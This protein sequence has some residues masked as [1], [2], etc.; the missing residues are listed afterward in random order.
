MAFRFQKRV[1]L[2]KGLGINISKSGI[3]PSY[4]TKRG[5]LS[6]K[7]YS[8]RTG[9]SGLN[10]RKTFSKGKNSGC[11]V[12][13]I[14]PLCMMLLILFSCSGDED[15]TP[16]RDTNCANYSSQNTAQAAFEADPECRNDLDRDNDG[17]ACEEPGNSV[18]NCASTSNCG[19]SNKNKA[20][21]EADP[22]CR[23]IVGEGC[24]CN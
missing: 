5:S 14:L 4:R 9:I 19:C 10:Y 3:T 24:S 13:L 18:K 16:C 11:L 23:W 20:P 17:I 6:S 12:V 8:I 2:G 15:K 7:G 22:C 1:K 21:C